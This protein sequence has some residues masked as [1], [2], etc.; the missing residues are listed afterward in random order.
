MKAKDLIK[1]RIKIEDVYKQIERCN[2]Q[3]DYKTVIPHYQYIDES[4]KLQLIQDGF[5]CYIADWD[6]IITDGFIIEW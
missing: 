4:V 5:K 2:E 3:G 1:R 6:L